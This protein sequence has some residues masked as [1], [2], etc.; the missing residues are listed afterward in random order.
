MAQLKHT[1]RPLSRDGAG[2]PEAPALHDRAFDNLRFIRETMERAGSFT[3]VSGAGIVGAGA[4]AVLATAVSA[5]QP[6]LTTWVW[7]WVVAA[8]LALVEAAALTA[9]KSRA[10]GLPL[11]SGPGRKAV[12]AFTPALVAGALLTLAL[13]PTGQANLLAGMWLLLYG[14]GVAAGGALSVPI[15]PVLGLSFLGLGAFALAAPAAWANW[16][17]LAGFGGLHI[18][19]GIAIAR[20]YGG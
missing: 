11:I 13:L 7:I 20:R 12:L 14:A 1:D 15:V 4:I 5:R 19:F 3:A 9:R 17:M 6:V 2:P 10:L 16:F 18:A 8:L